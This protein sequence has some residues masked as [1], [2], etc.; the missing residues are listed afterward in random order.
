VVSSAV[1]WLCVGLLAIPL[2]GSASLVGLIRRRAGWR[3]LTTWTRWSAAIFG[4][5][6][7]FRDENTGGLGPP[8]F[9]FVQLNQSSLSESLALPPG[10]PEPLHVL[11]NVEYALIPL[12]GWAHFLLGG[13]AIVRQW[14]WQTRKALRRCLRHLRNGRSVMLSIEGRRSQNGTLGPYK[15]G[16]AILAIT[17]QARIVPILVEGAGP[18]LPYGEW[19]VRPGRITVTLLPAVETSGLTLGDRGGLVER[20]RALAESRLN[21][22][23]ESQRHS[24]TERIQADGGV[25]D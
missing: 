14:K 12:L 7:E 19:R 22:A 25:D 10:L 1:R 18:C 11:M 6:T 2:L 9:V 8:P 4:I 5:E 13:V 20:L 21:G 17:A 23:T 24:D 15:K 3:L 16:P